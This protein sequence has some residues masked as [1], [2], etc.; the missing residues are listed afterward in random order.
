MKYRCLTDDELQ[1]LEEEFKHFLIANN[2]YTEEWEA[3]NANHD[4]RVIELVEMFSDIVFE[5]SLKKVRFLE[6]VTPAY[7]NFFYCEDDQ[8]TM[9]AFTSENNTIDFTEDV[10]PDSAGEISV[11]RVSKPYQLQR[12]VELFQLMESGAFI[13]DEERYKKIELVY[14]YSLKQTQN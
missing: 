8:I 13:I 12:E 7:M 11:Y 9:I 1:E 14:T 10:S 6:Q 5:K 2:V 3:L 4:K